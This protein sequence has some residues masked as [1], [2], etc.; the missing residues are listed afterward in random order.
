MTDSEYIWKA[1]QYCYKHRDKPDLHS[2]VVNIKGGIAFVEVREYG[3]A[4]IETKTQSNGDNEEKTTQW[5]GTLIAACNRLEMLGAD[6][7]TINM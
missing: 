5:C 3:E 1:L 6:H 4:F 2:F 7:E